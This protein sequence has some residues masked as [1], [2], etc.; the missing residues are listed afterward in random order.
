[1]I[2][3]GLHLRGGHFLAGKEGIDLKRSSPGGAGKAQREIGPP[4]GGGGVRSDEVRQPGSALHGV[5][6]LGA[7][8]MAVEIDRALPPVRFTERDR[9]SAAISYEDGG[10]VDSPARVESEIGARGGTDR[11]SCEG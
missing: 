11:H 10:D 2:R 3:P 9:S 4:V 5:G 8:R 6:E 7:R 1:M